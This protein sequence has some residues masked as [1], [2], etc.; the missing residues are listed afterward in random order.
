MLLMTS[1][2][3]FLFHIMMIIYT[4]FTCGWLITDI[5]VLLV[6]WDFPSFCLGGF[7]AIRLCTSAVLFGTPKTYIH[8]CCNSW[9]Q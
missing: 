4:Y 1:G 8:L 6:L 5:T 2:G 7:V 9:L 3:Q